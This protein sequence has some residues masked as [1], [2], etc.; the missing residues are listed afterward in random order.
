MKRK[1]IAIL[2][3][4]V[5][6]VVLLGI[7]GS[8]T[9]KPERGAPAIAGDSPETVASTTTYY[10]FLPRQMNYQGY[11]EDQSGN[12]VDGTHDLTFT[13]YVYS[14]A[15][16][17]PPTYKWTAVYSET[18]TVNVSDGLFNVV[19]GS[20]NPL[21]P[22]DFGGLEVLLG[23]D[24]ELGVQVD[25]GAELSPRVKL[26]PVPY[27]FRAEYVDYFPGPEYDSGWEEIGPRPD[28]ISVDFPHNLGGDPDDYVVDL[29]CKDTGGEMMQCGYDGAYW[30]ALT[31]T[32]VSVW[33]AGGSNPAALRVRI[34][35][36]HR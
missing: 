15:G 13:L 9:A 24:L 7:A 26:L 22:E 8:A 18:Q 34:W 11:L 23:G 3:L 27:A 2:I 6:L 4:S 33:V 31:D 32:S 16:G 30:Y 5:M 12:P 19:I 28:P 20:E 25:G 21:D 29:E 14:Y 35:Y 17:F 36:T 10:P 1:N